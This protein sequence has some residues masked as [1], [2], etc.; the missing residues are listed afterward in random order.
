MGG[1][2]PA[3]SSLEPIKVGYFN[4]QGGAVEVSHTNIDGVNN[5]VQYINE[6]AGGIG[7]HPLEIV[8]CY[9]ANAEEEGQQCGQQ[10][11]NDDSIVAV[12]SGP[13]FIGTESFYAALAGSKPVI[14]GVSV[15]PADT[16]QETAAVLYG[17]AKYILAPYA[18]FATRH[19]GNHVGGADLSRRRR[20]GRGRGRAGFGVRGGRHPDR[21]RV[22]PGRHGRPDGAADRRRRAGRRPRDAGHQPHRLRQV[23]AGDPAAR[24]PRGEGAR[25]PDLH[26]RRRRRGARRSA[27]VVLRR[28]LVAE[29]RSHRPLGAARTPTSST[30]QGNEAQIG[31]PWILVG[32]GQTMTL[33]KFLNAVGPDDLTPDAIVEQMKAFEGPLILGSPVLEC[34]KYPD[35]PGVCND[36]TQFYKYNG[37]RRMECGRTPAASSRPTRRVGSGIDRR[38]TSDPSIRSLAPTS[39][40]SA[41]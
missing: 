32:F 31:D 3:D 8:T 39:A 20:P 25:Q 4:Q 17:G 23:P 40:S 19:A 37:R 28:R 11:A 6:E 18:T 34:G 2:G 22:V 7:G 36:Y 30:A 5:A 9:V 13:T 41:E 16:V 1:S 38:A 29:H 33:A 15:S 27:A 14:H 21:G 35:A 12:I 10:F 24:D 26:Q